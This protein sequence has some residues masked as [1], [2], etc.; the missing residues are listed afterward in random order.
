MKLKK[1]VAIG[2]ASA[3]LFSAGVVIGAQPHMQNALEALHN[4]NSELE[5]ASHNKGGH[6]ERAI[7]LI[8]KAIY[9][10]QDGMDY[11]RR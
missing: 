7:E 8:N 3:L 6:R 1:V 11:A 10:V 5:K 2:L 9:E 4:A